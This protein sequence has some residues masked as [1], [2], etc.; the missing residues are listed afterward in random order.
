MAME[1]KETINVLLIEDNALFAKT[2]EM[3]FLK[4]PGEFVVSHAFRL[5][6][7]LALLSDKSIDVLLLDLNL[8]DSQ[9]LDTL[10][11]ALK[12]APEVPIVIMTG[13]DD[14]KIAREA[15]KSGA[16]EYIL[17][18]EVKSKE[19]LRTVSYAIERQSF[20]NQLKTKARDLAASELRFREIIEKNIDSAIIL[21]S[22]GLILYINP[23]AEKLLDITLSDAIGKDF[24]MC[25]IGVTGKDSGV[26]DE[27]G[28]SGIV[29]VDTPDGSPRIAEMK[30]VDI[31]WDGTPACFCALSNITEQMNLKEKEA[32]L[33][34]IIN[35]SPVITFLWRAE[36]DWPVEFVSNN[37]S[38]FGYVPEDFYSEKIKFTDLIHSDD[39]Y[40]INLY[41]QKGKKESFQEYRILTKDGKVCWVNDHT[42][43]KKDE[44]GKVTH[45][46][47]VVM[48]VT[49]RKAA[50]DALV[51]AEKEKHAILSSI[52]EVLLYVD[53][54]RNIIWG[55]RMAAEA[56]NTTPEELK[57]KSCMSLWNIDK[58]QCNKC[59]LQ[60]ADKSGGCFTE[61]E[62]GGKVWRISHYPVFEK[63]NANGLVIVAE[64]ITEQKKTESELLQVHAAVEEAMEAIIM[65]DLD[66]N[67][68][69]LNRAFTELLGYDFEYMKKKSIQ[70]LYSDDNSPLEIEDTSLDACSEDMWKGCQL[71]THLCASD[72]RLI[73]VLMR[74]TPISGQNDI[75]ASMLFV[76]GDLTRQQQEDKERKQLELQLAQSQKLESIGQMAAGI[77]HE[78]NTPTQFVGDNVN[79]FKDSFQS[80]IKVLDAFC[81]LLEAE[82]QKNVPP[83]LLKKIENMLE[84]EDFEYLKGEIPDAISQSISGISRI[85]S[86]VQGMKEF[87]H[88][89]SK[90]KKA[91]DINKAI[92]NTLTVSRNEWKYVADMETDF[93]K[94][95]P[96]VSCFP[97]ELNQV[98]LN[99]LVN[100]AHTVEEA[101][102]ARKLPKG[103]ITVK[104]EYG[105]QWFKIRIGDTGMGIPKEIRSKVFD[106]FFTTKEVGRGTG[107][108]LALAYDV[109]VNKHG[110]RLTFDSEEGKGTTFYIE[111]PLE[112]N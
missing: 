59:I 45:Y 35:A 60:N 97:G 94:N 21:D 14:G 82:K 42:W 109:I 53:K 61:L 78:I 75:P 71:T 58:E 101:N 29:H 7:G 4:S 39:I 91:T 37:I 30:T 67:A 63:D 80:I 76:I 65:T 95:S 18:T 92:E 81:E 6:A 31:L 112:N 87:S 54:D 5:D 64:D 98:I 79:F 16:Q 74:V 62:H 104:T 52:S 96:L 57:G 23:A 55:N 12:C 93:A 36:A 1:D 77:A 34:K 108:G 69:Y 49:D 89:S 105:D 19:L 48:D 9:G 2:I 106:L 46:Q 32:Q 68:I 88:P 28:Y 50:E 40:R 25:H 111:L 85:S 41:S 83:E 86:I 103:L 17:K 15:I 102:K 70:S 110:G 72:G 47:G 73:P 107:Q 56:F 8:P 38:Q 24:S 22:N 11:S 13:M 43:G 100:A 99:M 51:K 20:I 84:E 26:I 33:E 44:A 90:I 27:N 3:R 66:G 10:K